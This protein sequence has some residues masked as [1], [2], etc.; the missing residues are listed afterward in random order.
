V[1]LKMLARVRP[2]EI[3]HGQWLWRAPPED[4]SLRTLSRT[5]ASRHPTT[6]RFA[7]IEQCPPEQRTAVTGDGDGFGLIFPAPDFG[8]PLRW[9]H[10]PVRFV[11]DRVVR[12]LRSGEVVVYVGEVVTRTRR[13]PVS[14]EVQGRRRRKKK[15][16]EERR[17]EDVYVMCC[18]RPLPTNMCSPVQDQHQLRLRS[19]KTKI[20]SRLATVD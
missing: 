2:A 11:A 9:S 20:K 13:K 18:V 5:L 8:C 1:L 3:S 14:E 6:W 16:E 10:F 15:K 19:F 12:F 4:F 17:M 7:A